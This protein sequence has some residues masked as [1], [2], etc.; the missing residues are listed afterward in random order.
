MFSRKD[1]DEKK[2]ELEIRNRGNLDNNESLGIIHVIAGG[3]S[4][5]KGKNKLPS[6]DMLLVEKDIWK[7]QEVTF[8]LDDR[9]SKSSHND[10]LVV[11]IGLKV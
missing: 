7:K 11:S 10:P 4:S 9:M 5:C 6:E 2:I 3:L 1:I 8:S